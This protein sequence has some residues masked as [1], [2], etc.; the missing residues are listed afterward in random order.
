M[1]VSELRYRISQLEKANDEDRA[2]LDFGRELQKK[3]LVQD[4]SSRE[5]NRPDILHTLAHGVDRQSGVAYEL[6]CDGLTDDNWRI[7][8]IELERRIAARDEELTERR[9]QLPTQDDIKQMIHDSHDRASGIYPPKNVGAGCLFAA[10]FAAQR[11]SEFR[12]AVPAERKTRSGPSPPSPGGNM[13]LRS[14]RRS[15][16]RSR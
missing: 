3:W 8:I 6:T 2:Q 12:D 14:G 9:R 1:T 11:D 4:M 16:R 15:A 5:R 10:K 7:G 13:T